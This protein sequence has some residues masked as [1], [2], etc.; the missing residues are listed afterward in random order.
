MTENIEIA[1]NPY[2]FVANGIPAPLTFIPY[3]PEII[4]GNSKMIVI[5]ARNFIT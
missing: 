1:A 5:A 3:N 2:D 4:V